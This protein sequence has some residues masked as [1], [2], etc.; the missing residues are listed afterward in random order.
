MIQVAALWRHP[1]K[2]HG[3]EALERVTLKQGRTMPWDRFWAVTH[4]A[5]KFDL[6]APD[7][8][9]C[10]NFMIGARTPKLAGIWA[11]LDE[12][13]RQI[14]LRHADL[15]EITFR[16][17]V[18][19]D[20]TRFIKWVTPLC[21]AER[22]GPTDIVV[23]PDRGMTDSPFPSVSI[24]NIASHD[25]VQDALTSPIETERWRGNI[26]LRG[27]EPWAEHDWLGQDIK[28]GAATL[29]IR[30]RIKRCTV[31]NTNPT[32]GIRDTATLD[33]LNSTFGHQDF[34]VYAEVIEGGEIA[35]KDQVVLL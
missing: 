11:N 19:E 13:N 18:P 34:G 23:A 8:A 3:R 4:E 9:H 30:E 31:T 6:D 27:L 17:D 24:M 7:W 29:R 14:T 20:V 28:I 21:S 33:A 22:A 2:S 32:T 12:S 10:R 26:W 5:T 35:C 15:A 25:A 16:P 1:I